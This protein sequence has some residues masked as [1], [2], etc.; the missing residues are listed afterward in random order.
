MTE[1]FEDLSQEQEETERALRGYRI[2]SRRQSKGKVANITAQDVSSK[3]KL[4]KRVRTPESG[5]SAELYKNLE[6]ENTFGCNF[7]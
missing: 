4:L 1:I 7:T 6:T 2:I 3:I 5:F